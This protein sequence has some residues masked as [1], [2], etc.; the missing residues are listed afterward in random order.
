MCPPLQERQ[1]RIKEEENLRV[2]SETEKTAEFETMDGLKGNETIDKKLDDGGG[3]I[4][5][6]GDDEDVNP[7]EG[8]NE[9]LESEEAAAD[10]EYRVVQVV[11]VCVLLT[12]LQCEL[13]GFE[14]CFLSSSKGSWAELYLQLPFSCRNLQE[15]IHGR[16]APLYYIVGVV[17]HMINCI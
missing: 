15:N 11:E 16:Q 8:K 7:G 13:V 3:K 10:S 14:I 4:P 1:Q 5:D 12:S 9:L 6:D 17:S 2:E